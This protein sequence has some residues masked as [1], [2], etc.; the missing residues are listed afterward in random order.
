MIYFVLL[1]KPKEYSGFVYSS[2]IYLVLIFSS[3]SEKLYSDDLHLSN[4]NFGGI[5]LI[6]TPTARFTNDSGRLS[7]G[8][9]SVDPYNKITA[10]MQ[11]LPWLEGSIV[12]TEINN[13]L[14]NIAGFEKSNT[15]TYKDKGFNV[16]FKLLEETKLLP[17]LAFGFIDIGGTGFF[18]S[19]YIV[20]NKQYGN[21]DFSFGLGW[22]KMATSSHIKN[23]FGQ[24]SDKFYSRSSSFGSGGDIDIDN[25]F[26]GK[27]ASFFGGI[28]YQTPHPDI[29]LKLE[30][31]PN[32]F[33]AEP[34]SNNIEVDSPLNIGINYKISKN[35]DLAAGVERGNTFFFNFYMN[36]DL[37]QDEGLRIYKL[38]R[39][40]LLTSPWRSFYMIPQDGVGKLAK[41]IF[42][43][44][45]NEGIIA[46]NVTFKD[47]EIIAEIT[48]GRFRKSIR[49]ID[50]ASRILANNAPQNI[51]TITVVNVDFG[52]E[53]LRSSIDVS[54][55][56][57][58]ISKGPLEDYLTELP[59]KKHLRESKKPITVD[60]NQ[61]YPAFSW[62]L[63]P[64]VSS[65]IGGPDNFY[66]WKME[67]KLATEYALK[68]GLVLTSIFG[69]NIADNMSKFKYEPTT[70]TLY[71]VRSDV[72]EYWIE[73]KNGIRRME[74]DYVYNLT[75]NLM[76]SF[77]VGIFEEM[78]GGV[79]GELLYHDDN[80]RWAIGIETYKVKQR[81]FSQDF[82]FKAYEVMTG[83]LN[84]I[85]DFPKNNVR[86]KTSY[87]KYLAGDT[88]ITL[89]ISRR[90]Q[91]G[92]HVGAVA[93]FT[94]ATTEEYGE[95]GF[96]KWV[97]V[98]LPMDLFSIG[99]TR[100]YNTASWSPLTRDGGQKLATNIDLF[101]IKKNA[102]DNLSLKNQKKKY[103]SF[104]KILGGF[105]TKPIISE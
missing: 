61:L 67:A 73:G 97:Y 38:Q 19:D 5:G 96:S 46:H 41:Y 45:R 4:S 68:K 99:T 102:Y 59:N 23:P 28:Q 25:F 80:K 39:E 94:D 76:G 58:V 53:T 11:L 64:N 71:R 31:N 2:V 65:N 70:G 1:L 29:S 60:N 85:F 12:Y 14:Y 83:H 21:F 105:S 81:D 63:S 104:G 18:S 42:W 36:T 88:G 51:E 16:R 93:A 101:G 27:N 20:A 3:Y 30:Y 15:Q 26:S 79:G 72:K 86:L 82:S 92:T 48:Q 49:G 10:S 47:K 57:E 74:L 37:N 56:R 55:L 40:N 6:Q 17:S 84:L 75:E 95:G 90:F 54:E 13:R 7:F 34:I 87:G 44:M 52:V 78:F 22:G 24:I 91:N 9:S 77:S 89:D 69:I 66:I 43:Q 33:S 8:V 98:S 32:D 103:F 35:F 50:L 62:S 100:K